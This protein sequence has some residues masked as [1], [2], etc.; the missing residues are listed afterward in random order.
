MDSEIGIDVY[1]ACLHKDLHHDS[2]MTS[3]RPFLVKETRK[4]NNGPHVHE[5]MYSESSY[6]LLIKSNEF[7][8]TWSIGCYSTWFFLV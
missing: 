6:F 3:F 8:L 2:L 5:L 7:V 1:K 4:S